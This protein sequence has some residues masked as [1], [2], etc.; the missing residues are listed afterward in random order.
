[1]MTRKTIGIKINQ[2]R[3]GEIVMIKL[4]TI[5]IT[6]INTKMIEIITETTIGATEEKIEEM[7]EE[8]IGEKTEEKTEEKIGE[9]IGE[10]TKEM[11]EEKTEEKE[12]TI[13]RMIK[14]QEMIKT[15]DVIITGTTE[16]KIKTEMTEGIG[17][18]TKYH[19]MNVVTGEKG[20]TETTETTET[21]EEMRIGMKIEIEIGIIRETKKVRKITTA[22]RVR[23]IEASAGIKIGKRSLR[24]T[25]KRTFTKKMP[26]DGLCLKNLSITMI[27]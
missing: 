22:V 23:E 25:R 4:K 17:R 16:M 18:M 8:K 21:T 24:M 7:T 3:D 15:T 1:M 12:I 2:K 10:M 13:D 19:N 20:V 9:K 14:N 27:Q 5:K 26:M 11:T 6:I